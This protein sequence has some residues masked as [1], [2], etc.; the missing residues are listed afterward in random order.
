MDAQAAIHFASDWLSL[1][2]LVSTGAIYLKGARGPFAMRAAFLFA[3][4][5]LW[6]TFGSAFHELAEDLF[7]A[8]MAQHL[9]LI[10]IIAPLLVLGRPFAAFGAALPKSLRRRLA[11][12]LRRS[13][14]AGLAGRQSFVIFAWLA[15][16]GVFVFWHV[17]RPYAWSYAHEGAHYLE[18]ASLLACAYAFWAATLERFLRPRIGN[19]VAL[20]HV[21]S[22]AVVSGLPGALMILAARPFYP[23]HAAGAARWG[24]TLVEDQQLAG[25]I[26]WVPAGFIYLALI[27]ALLLRWIWQDEEESARARRR[28]ALALLAAILAPHGRAFAQP[29]EPRGDPRRGA[30]II[31]EKG[32]GACH[33]IPGVSGAHGTVGPP[34]TDVG[35]RVFLAGELRNTPDNMSAWIMNPQKFH[36]GT[37]MPNMGLTSAEAHDVTA[38]LERLH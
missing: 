25:L 36:P 28:M 29:P 34:L 17:P 13:G 12:L 38:Y 35:K 9:M 6:G 22:A 7:A 27:S 11:R 33:E 18:H 20:L 10:L 15:F 2:L 5:L 4:L 1:I 30:E 16:C 32:C 24:L 21:S 26:M 37:A 8:H 14:A 3:L 19:G 31:E 23:E